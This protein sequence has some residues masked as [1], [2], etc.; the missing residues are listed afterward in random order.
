VTGLVWEVK[1]ESGLQAYDNTYSWY[2]PD[3]T[4]NGGNSGVRNG[5][6][7]TGSACDTD[8]YIQKINELGLCRI[9]DWRL[10]TRQE[11]LSTVNNSRVKPAVDLRLFPHTTPGYYWSASPYADQETFAWQV[12]FLYGEAN[13]DEK[14]QSRHVRLVSGKTMT[15][16]LDNP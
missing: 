2:N 10:P 9:S 1:A 13:P 14:S 5:G 3:E 7:C 4:V 16:G 6:K 15:F 11:L 12:Y 8:A